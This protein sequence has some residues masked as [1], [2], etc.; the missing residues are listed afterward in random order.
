[1]VNLITNVNKL[2]GKM[3]EKGYNQD[4]LAISAKINKSTLS[5]KLKTGNFLIG[6][7]IEIAKVLE[8]TPEEVMN[9]FFCEY[10]A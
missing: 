2:K 7:V 6:E 4:K 3:V 10:V 9:I 8:L 1:V 5:R